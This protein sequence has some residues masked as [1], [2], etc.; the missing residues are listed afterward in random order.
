MIV[1]ELSEERGYALTVCKQSKEVN[2][3]TVCEQF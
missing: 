2:A 1:K 3:M